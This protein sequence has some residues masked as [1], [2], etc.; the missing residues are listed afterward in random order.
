[1]CVAGIWRTLKNPDGTDLHIT[2]SGEGHPIF[3]RM[4]KPTDEKRAVVILGP[5]DWEEWLTT[6]NVE[7][8]RLMLQRYS[9]VAVEVEPSTKVEAEKSDRTRR[10]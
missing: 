7:A 8:A 10:I 6:S 1:M 2:V 5:D 9:A 4:H 3:S